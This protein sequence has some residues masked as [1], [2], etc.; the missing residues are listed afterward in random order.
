MTI[1]EF[2][3]QEKLNRAF[4]IYRHYVREFI[5][6]QLAAY[7]ANAHPTY[8]AIKDA[9]VDSLTNEG[10]RS[11]F[12][13]Y[14]RDNRDDLK[15]TIDIAHFNLIVTRH[16]DAIFAEK[17]NNRTVIIRGDRGWKEGHL[18]YISEFRND[19]YHNLAK[20]ID[21]YQLERTI[22]KIREV[23]N[24]IGER[25]AG[26]AVWSILSQENPEQDANALRQ[27]RN[28]LAAERD[29]AIKERDSAAQALKQEKKRADEHERRI[30]DL[31]DK[32][33][34]AFP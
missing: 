15:G 29:A 2:P 27:D 23:L 10:Q 24:L 4:N 1:Q 25:E 26:N 7:H 21:G 18:G 14:L 17:F 28:Q 32:F 8:P 33:K 13:R 22:R 16:W 19:S 11:N 5:Y 31:E 6:E 20:D 30:R 34:Q 3:N 12:T 9:I